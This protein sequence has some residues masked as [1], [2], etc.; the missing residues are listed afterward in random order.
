MDGVEWAGVKDEELINYSRHYQVKER[1]GGG[2]K[3]CLAVP[4]KSFYGIPQNRRRAECG[5]G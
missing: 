2:G 3:E 5:G 4:L 1:G